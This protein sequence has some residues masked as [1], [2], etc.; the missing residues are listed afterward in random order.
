MQISEHQQGAVTVVVPNGPVAM[1]DADQL[2]TLAMQ[3]IERSMGRIVIDAIGVPFLDSR[4]LEVL[5]DV[6][7]KLNESG[8]ALKLCGV[9]E[10]VREIMELTDLAGSFEFYDDVNSAVRSFI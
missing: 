7:E 2:K 10:T 8:S 6:T 9:K 3:V 1:A 5:L 4:G